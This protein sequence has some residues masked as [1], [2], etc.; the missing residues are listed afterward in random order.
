LNAVLGTALQEGDVERP[1]KRIKVIDP[2]NCL[3]RSETGGK[4][5]E[6]G[7]MD[8]RSWTGKEEKERLWTFPECSAKKKRGSRR[9]RRMCFKGGERGKRDMNFLSAKIVGTALVRKGKK[10]QKKT[11]R[12]KSSW[13]NSS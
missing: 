12:R 10:S 8:G 7:P 2:Q 9:F 3:Y 6:F 4:E 13:S 11:T 1:Q 5:K